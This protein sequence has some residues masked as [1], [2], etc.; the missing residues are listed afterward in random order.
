MR[1]VLIAWPIA[2]VAVLAS[3]STAFACLTYTFDDTGWGLERGVAWAFQ[4]HVVREV[5]GEETGRP[6]VVV[7]E[8]DRTLVGEG[9]GRELSVRQDDGCDGF[10]YGTGDS[11]IVAVARYP[12]FIA[13]PGPAD[14]RRPPYDG[15]TNYEVAVW[16]L[17][18]QRVI[19]GEGPH[20]WTAVNG[21]RPET[22]DE[23]VSALRRLPDTATASVSAPDPDASWLVPALAG[24]LSCALTFWAMSRP[25]RV[26]G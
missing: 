3:S 16:V 9:S 12:G 24:T 23:V 1:R 14:R 25:R 13:D 6:E 20:S 10:W 22:A 15:L 4:G 7:I 26:R 18:G 8:V 17:D 11:V 21:I 5:S 2:I 19:P